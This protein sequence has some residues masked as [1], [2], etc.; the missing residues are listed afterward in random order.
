MLP[1]L[2]S[3]RFGPEVQTLSDAGMKAIVTGGPNMG[4]NR[5]RG[6]L[7]GLGRLPPQIDPFSSH[8]RHVCGA[9]R[10]LQKRS[11]WS[12]LNRQTAPHAVNLGSIVMK[13][14][15]GSGGNGHPG[16]VAFLLVSVGGG[17]R[18]TGGSFLYKAD[19]PSA[20]IGYTYPHETDSRRRGPRTEV[21]KI[22]RC[23]R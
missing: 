10:R 11:V 21:Y 14:P 2:G 8:L 16:L 17:E 13:S 18:P 20:D 5:L 4:S 9:N 22:A 23:R 12:L 7:R 1:R 15:A 6:A 3:R 19:S